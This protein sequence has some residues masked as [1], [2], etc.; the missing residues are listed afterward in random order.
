MPNVT[1]LVAEG[2]FEPRSDWF[3]SPG[4]CYCHPA[5]SR[6]AGLR[7]VFFFTKNLSQKLWEFKSEQRS[8]PPTASWSRS[9]LLVFRGWMETAKR[10]CDVLGHGNKDLKAEKEVVFECGGHA[11]LRD[12]R[13][14]V[15][16]QGLLGS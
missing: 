6:L 3:Q 8:I 1:Q 5:C 9:L 4:T 13:G 14:S 2:E 10:G 7:G 12:Q 15:M 16:G 11:H